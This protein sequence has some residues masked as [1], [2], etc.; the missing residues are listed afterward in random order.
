MPKQ[1]YIM[2]QES[3]GEVLASEIFLCH[4]TGEVTNYLTVHNLEGG[5]PKG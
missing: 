3:V 5:G 4:M 1:T 2:K